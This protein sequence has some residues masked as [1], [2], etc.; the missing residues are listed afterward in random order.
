M[1]WIPVAIAAVLSCGCAAIKAIDQK[2]P[3]PLPFVG[4]RWQVLLELPQPG[5]QPWV[6]FGDGRMEGFGGCSRFGAPIMQ[7]AVGAKAIA[8]MRIE[9]MQ[10]QVCEARVVAA[11]RRVIDVLQSV[12][13]YSIT[14][15]AMTMSGSA[16]SLKFRAVSEEARR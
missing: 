15:D 1:K 5:E 4:T 11:E 12:S 2:E 13:S 3:P 6:R 10:Q 8:V 14:V 9:R 16:G 7:D